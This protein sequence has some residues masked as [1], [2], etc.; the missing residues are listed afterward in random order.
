MPEI[1]NGICKCRCCQKEF[2]WV[3]Y[4]SEVSSIMRGNIKVE[5]IPDGQ[6]V[7][8][9]SSNQNRYIANCKHCGAEN[10]INM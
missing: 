7:R 3:Y 8:I 6:H 4:I 5:K 10:E 1:K 9:Q 2:K